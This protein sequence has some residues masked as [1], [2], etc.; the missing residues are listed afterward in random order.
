VIESILARQI[1][2][3]NNISIDCMREFAFSR[4]N[5]PLLRQALKASALTKETIELYTKLKTR[6]S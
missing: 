4:R 2:V 3:L 1:V 5:V 6:G